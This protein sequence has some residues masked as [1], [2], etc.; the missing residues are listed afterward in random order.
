M[1]EAW[2]TNAAAPF[3]QIENAEVA[4]WAEGKDRFLITWPGGR[5][6]VHNY[7]FASVLAHETADKLGASRGA[8]LADEPAQ[9]TSR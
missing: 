6:V 1:P 9:N 4:V 3:L 2:Q 7:K 5:R 8:G